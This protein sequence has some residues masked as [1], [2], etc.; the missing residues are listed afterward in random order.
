MFVHLNSAV[1]HMSYALAFVQHACM[2]GGSAGEGWGQGG[3]LSHFTG[4]GL[5]R[6][7]SASQRNLFTCGGA[8]NNCRVYI[9]EKKKY[10]P[11]QAAIQHKQSCEEKYWLVLLEDNHYTCSTQPHGSHYSLKNFPTSPHFLIRT[12]AICLTLMDLKTCY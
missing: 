2:F 3:V 10:F 4:A 5:W 12:L 6:A 1:L 7:P 11:L 9:G 8:A